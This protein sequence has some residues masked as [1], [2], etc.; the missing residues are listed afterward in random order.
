MGKTK[1]SLIL[2]LAGSATFFAGLGLY[3]SI[4]SL[5]PFEIGTAAFVVLV[6]LG[7]IAIA[8]GK[9]KDE[10]KGLPADDEMSN[11]IKEKA[12]ARAFAG[13]FYIWLFILLFFSNSSLDNELIIGGG[14]IA[15]GAVFMGFWFYYTKTGVGFEDQ[16]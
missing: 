14:L 8:R 12:G 3:G 9:L 13:S 6:T 7:G 10:K 11:I 2:M 5:T 16:N 1:I 15:M 4:E